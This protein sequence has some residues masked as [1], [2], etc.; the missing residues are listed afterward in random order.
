[1]KRDAAATAAAAAAA[2][3]L[4]DF[5]NSPIHWQILRSIRERKEKKNKSI[6]M[7]QPTTGLL[8]AIVFKIVA[9][10]V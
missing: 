7:H 8:S 4:P 6:G 5:E 9:E 2:A 10:L 1:M 3:I